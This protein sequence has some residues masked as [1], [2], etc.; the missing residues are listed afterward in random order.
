MIASKEHSGKSIIDITTGKRLGEVKGLYLNADMR[1][2]MAVFLG[3]EGFISRKALA[4]PQSAV[5]VI[6]ADAWL[7]ASIDKILP[8]DNQTD[9]ATFVL[10]SDLRGREIQTEGGTKIGVVEDVL[11]DGATVLGFALGKVYVQGPLAE[12]KTIAREAVTALGSKDAPMTAT[13][14]QAEALTLPAA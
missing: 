1:Q 3:T 7:A 9:W 10:V 5:Q 4:L 6:G 14:S 12:R 13:L 2:V 8:L 11:L